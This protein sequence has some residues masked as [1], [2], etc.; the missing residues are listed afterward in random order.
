MSWRFFPY[1]LLRATGLP[2]ERLTAVAGG[3]IEA[4]RQR[5]FMALSDPAAREAL[6]TSA[7]LVDANFD[8]WWAHAR[9]GRRNAQDKKRERV[10]WRFLQRLTA[11][12]DSTSFF[13][14]VAAGRFD[15]EMLGNQDNAKMPVETSR[16]A[17]T[18][19]WVVEQLLAK[20]LAELRASGVQMS[21]RRRAPGADVEGRVWRPGELGFVC[22]DEAAEV[23]LETLPSGLLDPVGEATARLL[24]LPPS[25]LRDVWIGRLGR[26]EAGRLA[27]ARTARRPEARR[28][29]IASHEA[30]VTEL[31]GEAR[32]G[33]GEFYASRGPLHEQAD[34]TGQVLGLPA[35]WGA[36][37]E[38]ALGPILDLSLLIQG[39]E[40]VAFRHWFQQT[41]GERTVAWREVLATLA[42][43]PHRVDLDAPPVV[44][45]V[46]ASLRVIRGDLRA[47]IDAQGG[48]LEVQLEPHPDV[49]QGLATLG[50]IGRAYANPDVMV[51]VSRGRP[52][53]VLAE[54]HYLP[55][56]TGC[57]LP[58]LE[59]REE[60]IASTRDFLQGLAA[61]AAPA[62]PVSWDHSFISVGPDFGA[63]G[64]ELSGLAREPVARR[65][66]FAELDCRL[67][68]DA[69]V[70]E[71]TT[72]TGERVVVAPMTRTARL[73]Q[74]AP[75]F[76]L[77]T[78]EVG[79]FLA[80]PDWKSREQLPRLAYGDT[81]VHRR[82]FRLAPEDGGAEDFREVLGA[83]ARLPS[84]AVP[85][86]MFMRVPSEPKPILVDWSSALARDLVRWSLA[87][88]ETVDLS[89]ML[90]A[91]D[92]CWLEGPEGHH[93]AE[94]R[95]VIVRG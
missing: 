10:L 87:R 5:L 45:D 75:V 11:K 61:P 56:L 35:G 17:F 78:L 55:H 20:A 12:N 32:R 83:R 82:R 66:T 14:A 6:M 81:V 22:V 25:A 37:M 65:A 64:L 1:F 3:G 52:R 92:E 76:P 38:A 53:W 54:A 49:A 29:V 30:L 59:A 68:G 72:H 60:V 67:D 4:E 71:V 46:R 74:A 43:E 62:F 13:G 51:A 16:Q 47:Q 88:G 21:E 8:G 70:F 80:G 84:E 15:F 91:P 50:P 19:Q 58:A 40:R 7:P 94:L 27:F 63:I 23:D 31:L 57:L 39:A 69:F 90:P 41:F 36:R 24:T 86:F 2:V 95:A 18:T 44:R 48:T 33:G 34:R 28:E 93:T 26:L 9:A 73:H 77:A 89:E 79:A 85:R 42:K